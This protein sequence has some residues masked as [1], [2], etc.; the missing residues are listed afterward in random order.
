MN[1]IHDALLETARSAG[2]NVEYFSPI[3][4]LPNV[5]DPHP[6]LFSMVIRAIPHRQAV[7]N[8]QI[9][10]LARAL[11]AYGKDHVL[12]NYQPMHGMYA[13]P[14]RYMITICR[15]QWAQAQPVS[16]II[17]ARRKDKITMANIGQAVEALV[18][19]LKTPNGQDALV[20]SD[21]TVTDTELDCEGSDGSG[22]F[23]ELSFRT[24]SPEHNYSGYYTAVFCNGWM[25]V[26]ITDVADHGCSACAC[27]AQDTRRDYEA[28]I[29]A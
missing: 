12:Y 15:D 6:E 7:L 28:M 23:T 2:M 17:T 27:E 13:A 11:S 1:A 20:H 26:E 10:D 25:D 19:Y 29:K 14:D 16:P 4:K 3:A 18:A 21:E 5:L 22:A 9:S 24:H 8:R